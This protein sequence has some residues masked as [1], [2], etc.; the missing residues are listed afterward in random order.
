MQSRTVREGSVGLL[1]LVG[2]G[3]FGAIVL[4]L[5][6]LQLGVRSYQI[7]VEFAN[8]GGV[9]LGSPV[10]FRGVNVGRVV[11]IEPGANGVAVT[12]E[13]TPASVL[14]P[15]NTAIEANQSGFVGEVF[16]DFTPESIYH[17]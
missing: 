4:W 5:R 3:L 7:V 10:R 9:T 12:T 6:G 2:I 14:I 8:T 13:I 11:A 17:Q 16:I 1:L 15:R